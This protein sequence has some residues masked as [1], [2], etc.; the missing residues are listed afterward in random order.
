MR[1][2]ITTQPGV[3]HLHPLL[4][5]AAGLRERGHHA[6]FA[7]SAP[8]AAEIVA[9]GFEAFAVGRDWLAVDMV[10]AFPEVASKPAGPQRYAWARSAVFAGETARESVP[11]LIALSETWRPDL[12]V[13]EAAEYGGCVAAELLD[14]PHAVVR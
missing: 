1:V 5:V 9:A 6:A 13:R 12:I 8:F 2:L 7:S 10:R 4:P 14:V 3:G 11:D